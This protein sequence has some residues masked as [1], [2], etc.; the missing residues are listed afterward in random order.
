MFHKLYEPDYVGPVKAP[1]Y[2]PLDLQTIFVC[3]LLKNWF[4]V[5]GKPIEEKHFAYRDD[6]RF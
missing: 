2:L 6:V 3:A 4:Q 1:E 5:D